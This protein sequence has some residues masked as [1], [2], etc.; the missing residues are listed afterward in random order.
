MTSS[1][2]LNMVKRDLGYIANNT[3]LDQQ[4]TFL[5]RSA[6]KQIEREGIKLH[7]PYEIDEASLLAMYAAYLWRKR[8]T[9]EGMPRMLRYALNNM[10]MEQKGRP[11]VT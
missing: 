7:D 4:L 11:D 6:E 8:A 5:I 1:D 2:V 3:A 10:L 9:D